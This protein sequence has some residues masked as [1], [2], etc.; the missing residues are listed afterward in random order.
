MATFKIF[1]ISKAN[2]RIEELETQLTAV[3]KER[4]EARTALESNAS[5]VSASAEQLQRDL[6]TAKQTI[7]TLTGQLSAATT[8]VTAKDTEIA[9]LTTKLS[10]KDGE[11]KIQVAQQV[12]QTQA[13][14]GQPPMPLV[15][16]GAKAATN[17]STGLEKIVAGCR[18]GL[19]AGGFKRQN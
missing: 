8:T 15:P 4:D 14:L 5:E 18:A 16:E 2:A 3:T 13:A 6:D 9:A 11:V 17:G 12:A 10:S 19:E 7:G 1:H